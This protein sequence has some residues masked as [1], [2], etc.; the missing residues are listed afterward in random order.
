LKIYLNKIFFIF[1]SCKKKLAFICFIFIFTTALEL[2]GLSL[3]A[4]YV[5]IF[6]EADKTTRYSELIYKFIS[7]KLS[8]NE[9][10][11]LCS[12]ILSL[13][14]VIKTILVIFLNYK[15]IQFAMDQQHNIRSKLFSIYQNL[16]YEYFTTRNSS[17]YIHNIQTLTAQFTNNIVVSGLKG[18]SEL[19]V[20]FILISFLIY[21]NPFLFSLL[22]FLMVI[23]VLLYDRGFKKKLGKFGKD[24]NVCSDNMIKCL[25]ETVLGFKELKILK[26][27]DY[28]KTR[29]LKYSHQYGKS[30]AVGIIVGNIP[31]YLFELILFLFLIVSVIYSVY[32]NKGI[33]NFLP[34]LAV[35]CVASIR[36]VPAG[37]ILS[38]S[39]VQLR[40]SKDCISRL[41]DDLNIKYVPIESDNSK[42]TNDDIKFDSLELKDVSFKYKKA[43]NNTLSCVNF[44]INKGS[45]IGI[46]GK[47]G[48]GK[49]TLVDIMLGLL[50][51]TQGTILINNK[52]VQEDYLLNEIVGY[53]PQNLFLIDDTIKNNIAL[54]VNENEIDL[55]K[56]NTSLRKANLYD[57]VCELSGGINSAIGQN[58]INLSGGQRQR[59]VLAR[60]FYFNKPILILDEST[61][62]LDQETEKLI[63]SEIK[64]LNIDTTIVVISHN[65]SV[66]KDCDYVY[67]VSNKCVKLVQEK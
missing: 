32:S 30:Y 10:I 33:N 17:E 3:I 6:I 1:G 64:S 19:F 22:F 41:Y 27:L 35:F 21:I 20:T 34:S 52:L 18:I 29:M 42:N 65:I 44:K 51:P 14:I 54:G 46:V 24:S 49:S 66:I 26:K 13:I 38:R 47:S 60:A 67:N 23:F 55:L 48:S 2:L 5:S 36:L 58:G 40:F 8:S 16:D 45:L 53:L 28:F 61:S 11:I 56:L 57:Y 4:P 62:A 59:I 50:K 25:N 9:I 43:S 39:L 7:F 63:I 12:I 37:N 31:R 15:I